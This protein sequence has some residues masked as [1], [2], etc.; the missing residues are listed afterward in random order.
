MIDYVSNP[1]PQLTLRSR[2][3]FRVIIELP[4]IKIDYATQVKEILNIKG[5]HNRMIVSTVTA[6]LLSIL[7]IGGVASGRV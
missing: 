5:N 7:P 1:F 4:T 6:I 2:Y 3:A